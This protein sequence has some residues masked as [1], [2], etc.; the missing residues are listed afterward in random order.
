MQ[1]ADAMHHLS[2]PVRVLDVPIHPWT[3]EQTVREIARRMDHGLFTQHGAANAAKLVNMRREPGLR[4]ALLSCDII[5][6]DGMS[7][8]FAARLLRRPLP[9]R[10]AGIDLFLRMAALAAERGDPIFL[11]GGEPVIAESAAQALQAREPRLRIAGWHHGY[12]WD[13]E[14]AIARKIRESG[15]TMLFVG[16]SSPKKEMFIHRWRRELGVRFVMGVGGAFDI[17]AGKTRRSPLWMQRAGL[18]WLFRLILEPRRLWRRYLV[19]N[20]LFVWLLLKE[21]WTQA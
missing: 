1:N 8:V 11:L 5:N 9:G 7:V 14:A 17:L 3:I 13:D 4:E 6:A 2:A 20:V 19:T 12:I 16:I 10:V 18:E 15:A 21:R